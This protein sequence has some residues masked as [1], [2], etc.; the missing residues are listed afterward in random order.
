MASRSISIPKKYCAKT[1]FTIGFRTI[2]EVTLMPMRHA[3]YQRN[4]R[5]AQQEPSDL[6]YG[7]A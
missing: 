4:E 6:G 7:L 2:F 3:A 1:H 5:N